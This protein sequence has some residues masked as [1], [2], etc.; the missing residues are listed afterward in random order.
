[1][2]GS[3]YTDVHLLAEAQQVKGSDYTDAHL[4]AEARQMKGSHYTD[5]P[6]INRIDPKR[7]GACGAEAKQGFGQQMSTP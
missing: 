4:L 5:A 6:S 3:D 7:F 2:E 1:M